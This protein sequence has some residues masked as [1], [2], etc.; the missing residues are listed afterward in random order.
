[1]S[2]KAYSQMMNTLDSVWVCPTC[3]NDNSSLY[4]PAPSQQE[5]QPESGDN[6]I[7]ANTKLKQ[8]IKE[9][10]IS[11]AHIKIRG[12]VKNLSEVKIL[13]Q[14]TQIDLLA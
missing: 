1:M 12:L 4:R 13:P 10:G 6:D 8:E 2:A 14:Y 7:E 5:G 3:T 9:T 11:V